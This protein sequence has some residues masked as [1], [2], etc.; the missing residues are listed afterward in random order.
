MNTSYSNLFVFCNTHQLIFDLV[1]CGTFMI[2]LSSE[3]VKGSFILIEMEEW[4][5]VPKIATKKLPKIVLEESIGIGVLAYDYITYLVGEV[6]L[7]KTYSKSL[8]S[9]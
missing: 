7:S 6:E 1:K 8:F 9:R 4:T 2:L 5:P 3:K